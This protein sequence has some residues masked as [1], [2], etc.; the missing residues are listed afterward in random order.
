MDSLKELEFTHRN[1]L[2]GGI[3]FIFFIVTF[4]LHN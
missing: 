4:F 2:L 3:L 1:V